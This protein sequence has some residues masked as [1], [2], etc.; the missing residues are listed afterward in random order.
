MAGGMWGANVEELRGLGQTLQ[1]KG[2]EIRSTMQQLNSQIQSVGWEGP[3]AQQFKGSDW[4]AAQT[5]LNNV[6]QTL[7]DAGQKAQQNAQQQEQASNS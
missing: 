1:Q 4:P 6:A 3:D 7:T 2:D 5:Q